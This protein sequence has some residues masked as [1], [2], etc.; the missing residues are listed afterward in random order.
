M[1][2]R[3]TNLVGH[4]VFPEDEE[5]IKAYCRK[6]IDVEERKV[7]FQYCISDAPGL[8][9]LI[10]ESIINKN[11][12]YRTLIKRGFQIPAKEDDFYAYRRKVLYGFYDWLRM[13]GRWKD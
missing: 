7:L 4:G 6:G 12:G 5:K 1:R 8:E 2:I 11:S 9:I 13:S 3:D 10:F